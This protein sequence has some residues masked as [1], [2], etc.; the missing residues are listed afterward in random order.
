MEAE[1]TKMGWTAR[2]GQSNVFM[3]QKHLEGASIVAADEV[4]E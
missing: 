4:E 2:D 3:L 1:L